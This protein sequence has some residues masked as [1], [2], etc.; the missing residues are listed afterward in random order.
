MKESACSH[1]YSN[2]VLDHTV[3]NI[4]KVSLKSDDIVLNLHNDNHTQ[5]EV[6]LKDMYRELTQNE[7]RAL[8]DRYTF[9]TSDSVF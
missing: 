8:K 6:I 1:K 7:E 9:Q 4:I 2:M 5:T 3:A